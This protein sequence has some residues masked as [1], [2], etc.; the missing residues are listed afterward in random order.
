M[1]NTTEF[2]TKTVAQIEVGDTILVDRKVRKIQDILRST[3]GATSRTV[4]VLAGGQLLS[5]SNP[6]KTLSVGV[7]KI[8]VTLDD[9]EA[10]DLVWEV[11]KAMELQRSNPDFRSNKNHTLRLEQLADS[12]SRIITKPE[13]E[14]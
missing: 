10:S 1:R 13:E 3:T 7:K 5:Y 9:F 2:D 4:L 12:L 6:N 8:T 11:S 14:S